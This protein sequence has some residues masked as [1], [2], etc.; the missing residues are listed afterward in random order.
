MQRLDYGN[1]VDKNGRLAF[2]RL[3]D[4][5]K[6]RTYACELMCHKAGSDATMMVASFALREME[7]LPMAGRRS[8]QINRCTGKC[9]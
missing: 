8:E 3:K 1:N 2:G 9:R 4:A 7:K 5:F 6:R